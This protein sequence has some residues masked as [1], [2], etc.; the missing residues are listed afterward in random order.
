MARKR[1]VDPFDAGARRDLELAL[2]SY[3]AARRW[4]GGKARKIAR[5]EILD[6]VPLPGG[7]REARFALSRVEYAEGEAETYAAPLAFASGERGEQVRRALPAATRRA[8][9]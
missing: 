5:V 7:S 6:A 3:L 2:P 8:R 4:F 1:E 9:V